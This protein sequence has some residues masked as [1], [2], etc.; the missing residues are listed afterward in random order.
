MWLLA[1][2]DVQL[3]SGRRGDRIEVLLH[4]SQPVMAP[5]RSRRMSAFAPLAGV[6]RTFLTQSETDAADPKR[7]FG[8]THA[9]RS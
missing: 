6:N 9:Y 3:Q 5:R 7:S 4:C 2:D 8:R 1:L